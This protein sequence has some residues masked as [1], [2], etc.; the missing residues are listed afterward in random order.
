MKKKIIKW[1]ITLLVLVIAICTV[2]Y[3]RGQMIFSWQVDKIVFQGFSCDCDSRATDKVELSKDEIK[4]TIWHYNASI[5]KRSVAGEGCESDFSFMIY[6]KDGTT[7]F[8]EEA[9]APRIDVSPFL[10]EDFWVDN[11]ALVEYAHE[12]IQKYNLVVHE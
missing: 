1:T 3:L 9:G 11:E 5:N 4:E 8:I 7:I 12:L 6:L 2:R 10:G